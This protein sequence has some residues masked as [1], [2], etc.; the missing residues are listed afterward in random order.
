MNTTDQTV[1]QRVNEL[2]RRRREGSLSRRRFLQGATALGLSVPL[3]T[4]LERGD[5]AVLQDDGAAPSGELTIVMQRVLV[6]LD[7]HGAQSVEEPTAVI[8]SHIFGSLLTRDFDTGELQ[9]SLATAWEAVDETTWQFTLQ[10]G[11][12]WQDG[13]PFTSADVKFSLERVLELEGPLAPL[14]ALTESVEAPDDLTV[15]I[16]TTEPQGTV[17]VSATLFFITPAALTNDDGFFDAP[18]GLGPYQFSSWT[19]DE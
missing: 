16:T 17:P 15:V 7:P 5:A 2:L 12:T 3:A 6:S 4:M 11:I 8:A 18:V 19:R 13:T 10:D 9:P 14:W 1:S